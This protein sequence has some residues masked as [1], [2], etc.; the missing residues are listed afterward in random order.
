MD[1]EGVVT[2]CALLLTRSGVD[3]VIS[4]P[5]C[6]ERIQ[7][8]IGTEDES[9]PIPLSDETNGAVPKWKDQAVSDP[10]VE[11]S[12]LRVLFCPIFYPSVCHYPI[13]WDSRPHV[14]PLS[15]MN[16]PGP[17]PYSGRKK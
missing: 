9:V 10:A 6:W 8:V 12:M 2:R 3:G 15:Q 16:G 4:E 14:R 13:P 7:S 1:G 11:G 17:F 5:N